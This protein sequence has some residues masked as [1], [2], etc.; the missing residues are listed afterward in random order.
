MSGS[1]E[2]QL[3]KLEREQN[4]EAYKK[5]KKSQGLSR[6]KKV[7]ITV[8]SCVICVLLI[9]GIIAAVFMQSGGF[10]RMVTAVKVGDYSLSAADYNYYYYGSYNS[11]VN[12]Y[13]QS[14]STFWA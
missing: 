5:K 13:G 4:P 14:L 8:I 6:G 7:A 12:Q 11:F 3:R 1:R 9:G 2:K 10:T